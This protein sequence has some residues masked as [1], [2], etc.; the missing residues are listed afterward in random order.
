MQQTD[1]QKHQLMTHCRFLFLH[2]LP[3]SP[4]KILNIR[5]NHYGFYCSLNKLWAVLPVS[6]HQPWMCAYCILLTRAFSVHLL[7]VYDAQN[8][9]Y[10]HSKSW[11]IFGMFLP[12]PLTCFQ[13]PVSPVKPHKRLIQMRETGE[14][15]WEEPNVSWQEHSDNDLI[16]QL[17]AH[18][19]KPTP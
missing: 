16:S 2:K 13:K 3:Q 15:R 10:I 12:V 1:T 5:F 18:L 7:S 8:K 19:S 11:K 4:T 17:K 14:A 9:Q 6:K